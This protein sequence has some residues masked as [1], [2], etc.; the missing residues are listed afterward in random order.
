MIENDCNNAHDDGI[1][2]VS[3][4]VRVRPLTKSEEASGRKNLEGL[5]TR[6]SSKEEEGNAVAMVSASGSGCIGGFNGVLGN[7]ASNRDVFESCFLKRLPTV[8]HGGIA[9]LFCYGYTGGGKTHTV[10]GYGKERGLFFLA[11]EKLLHDLSMIQNERNRNENKEVICE[12]EEND[13]ILFLRATAC[14]IY[15]D[16]VYDI[17]GPEKERCA[18]RVGKDGRLAVTREPK[19]EKLEGMDSAIVT[20]APALRSISVRKPEDLDTLSKSCVEQR[21][22]GTS[23]EN[24]VSS[25][26]HAILR[27]EVVSRTTN[28]AKDKIQSLQAEIPAI[29][30][31][32]DHFPKQQWNSSNKSKVGAEHSLARKRFPNRMGLRK[33]LLKKEKEL[34]YATKELR[35]LKTK[36]PSALGGNMLLVDLAGAD[37]DHRAG[38]AQKESV[39]T[40]KS[41]LALKECFRALVSSSSGSSKSYNPPFRNSNLTRILKDSLAPTTDKREN[42]CVMVVNVC[43]SAHIK[44]GTV[45]ALRYGQMYASRRHNRDNDTKRVLSLMHQNSKSEL[46]KFAERATLAELRRIYQ[47]YV[48]EKTEEE[49]DAIMAK[50][51]GREAGLLKTLKQKYEMVE[52]Y[53]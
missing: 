47:Q 39:S 40:N 21:A 44:S 5:A 41:L 52:C 30:N 50:F 22:C 43:P 20:I 19:S 6:N 8:L 4:F 45:N 31:A 13:D 27:L 35:L 7:E 12:E 49:V 23:T 24:H 32:I 37:Y 25:R 38:K 48:P 11:A 3:V 26:S 42:V 17:L 2:S 14:E 28:C 9:S 51:K 33:I 34:I 46:A 36:G 53:F 18:L 29:K 1:G 10:V 15:L 16:D